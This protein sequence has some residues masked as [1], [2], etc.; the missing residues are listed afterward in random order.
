MKNIFYIPIILY[1]LFP[2]QLVAQLPKPTA[3]AILDVNNVEIGV[4]NTGTIWQSDHAEGQYYFPND[5]SKADSLKS[6]LIFTGGI[7]MKARETGGSLHLAAQTYNDTNEYY[8]G[9]IDNSGIVNSISCNLWNRI[10]SCTRVDINTFRN[11]VNSFGTPVSLSSIPLDIINWPGKGNPHLSATGMILDH[12]IAPFVDVNQ[13]GIY[14]PINGDFPCIKGDKSLFYVINDKGP[15]R[16]SSGDPLN[17]EIHVLNYSFKKSSI[18]NNTT[19]YDV[20]V[21]NRSINN[22]NDFKLGIF[23]DCDL[24]CFNNDYVA[25]NPSKNLAIG[26]NAFST[27]PC[28]RG[29]G[30]TPAVLGV[31]FLNTPLNNLGVQTGLTS[32]NHFLPFSG[33]QGLPPNTF[34]Y[35]NF[36][37]GLWSDGSDLT[38]NGEGIGGTIPTKFV[39]PGNP[40]IPSQWSEHHNQISGSNLSI[41]RKFLMTT[42]AYD[43]PINGRLNFTFAVLSVLTDSSDYPYPNFDSII[44]PQADSVQE[45]YDAIHLYCNDGISGIDNQLDLSS[46]ATV[47]PNPLTGN[48]LNIIFDNDFQRGNYDVQIRNINGQIIYTNKMEINS[49]KQIIDLSGVNLSK[50]FYAIQLQKLNHLIQSKFIVSE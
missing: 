12:D 9:P 32:F 3:T 44:I 36:L 43:L 25:C 26:Y 34:G 13:D 35:N 20:S 42:G 46:R 15:H 16:V 11:Y 24:G 48:Q 10:F 50:G 7:W 33:P 4:S 47:F 1:I 18:I 8:A 40:S 29:Y 23:V 38:L 5:T 2:I 30:N 49:T 22:Y 14:D 6:R 19:F 31:K 21:L 28:F 17:A 27:D 41:D 37:D 45:F 39:F